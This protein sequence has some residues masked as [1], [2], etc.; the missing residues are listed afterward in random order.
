M[1]HFFQWILARKKLVR[2]RYP[3]LGKS[4]SEKDIHP[5]ALSSMPLAWSSSV[6]KWTRALN[7]SRE[8]VCR[9]D[10]K[11][12]RVSFVAMGGRE[13]LAWHGSRM[14]WHQKQAIYFIA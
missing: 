14:I 12:D 5:N 13:V 1:R 10:R 3:P 6:L 7:T 4:L 2:E 11:G 9:R 8:R